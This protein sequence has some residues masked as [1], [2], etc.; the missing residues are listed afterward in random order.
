MYKAT[1]NAAKTAVQ[2]T[3]TT[4]YRIINTDGCLVALDNVHYNERGLK[5]LADRIGEKIDAD[6][7]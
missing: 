6:G 3:D 4:N 1:I 5:T 2:L 7:I